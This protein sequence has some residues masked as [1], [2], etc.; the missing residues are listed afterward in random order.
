[1]VRGSADRFGVAEWYGRLIETIPVEQRHEYGELGASKLSGLPCPFRQAASPGAECKKKGGVCTLRKHT[2]APDGTVTVIPPLVTLCPSRFWE[3]NL[4]FERIGLDILATSQPT[5]VKE[6]QFLA[7]LGETEEAEGEEAVGRIDTII[8]DPDDEQRWCAL[9]LQA[10]Y[11]SGEKMGSHLAQ[12]SAAQ[13]APVYP[14]KNRRPD[15]RSSGPKRLMP[16]LQIKVP[17]LR[18][19]GKKMAVVVDKPF[20][21]SLGNMVKVN[22]LS[23]ADI[24]WYIVNYDESGNIFVEDTR[25]TTLES[26]VE[27]LTAG[28]P[29]SQEQFEAEFQSFLHARNKRARSKVIRLRQPE[30]SPDGGSIVQ[31][32]AELPDTDQI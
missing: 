6:V 32:G 2:Q 18:R 15:Y 8:V 20:Y 27:A 24:A 14:D 5:L 30:P 1:M 10:V 21:G 4:I 17:T 29:L 16:Q 19:W 31:E 11:F 25:F 3:G 26:S 9:E 13:E 7:S 23:N 28:K 22:H 12:Y